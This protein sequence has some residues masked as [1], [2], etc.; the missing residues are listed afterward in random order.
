[1]RFCITVILLHFASQ[2]NALSTWCEC[3]YLTSWKSSSCSDTLSALSFS[4]SL[5]GTS[6][7][8]RDFDQIQLKPTAFVSWS[9]ENKYQPYLS[10]KLKQNYI[11]KST[12]KSRVIF[13]WFPSSVHSRVHLVTGVACPE[14][15]K[16]DVSHISSLIC[17]YRWMEIWICIFSTDRRLVNTNIN[18]FRIKGFPITFIAV[19]KLKS[20]YQLMRLFG[21]KN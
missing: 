2:L 6:H 19:L 12:T 20:C 11:Q 10:S 21:A 13:Y 8:T 15:P 5:F 17:A 16:K 3:V 18:H 7:H 14:I 1:M 9:R 4:F